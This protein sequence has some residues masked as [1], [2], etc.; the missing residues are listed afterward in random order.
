MFTHSYLCKLILPS[1]TRKKFSIDR[2]HDTLVEILTH[3]TKEEVLVKWWVRHLEAKEDHN[4]I[5]N[6]KNLHLG[7][8]G[9]VGCIQD[10]ADDE[11]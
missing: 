3:D 9:L 4:I 5:Q 11:G 7:K 10:M 8:I 1:S 6:R 2:M